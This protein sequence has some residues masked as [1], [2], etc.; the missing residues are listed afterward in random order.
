MLLGNPPSCHLCITPL[1]SYVAGQPT[2]MPSMHNTTFFY[3][4]GQPTIMPSMQNTTFFYVAGQPTH[5]A[6][7]A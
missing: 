2:I 5:H 4:A 6:I 1:F 7:Y 3:V